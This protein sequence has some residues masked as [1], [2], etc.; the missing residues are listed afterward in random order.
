MIYQLKK[1]LR[2]F[3]ENRKHHEKICPYNVYHIEGKHCIQCG[4]YKPKT[5]IKVKRNKKLER[6]F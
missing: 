3:F 6:I 4:H 1:C 5:S 2:N